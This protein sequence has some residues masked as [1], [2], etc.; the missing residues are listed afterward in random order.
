MKMK[1][2]SNI[3][4]KNNLALKELSKIVGLNREQLRFTIIQSLLNYGYITDEHKYCG[5]PLERILSDNNITIK[6]FAVKCFHCSYP[7]LLRIL[8]GIIIWGTESACPHCGCKTKVRGELLKC[9]NIF[10]DF[11]INLIPKKTDRIILIHL[12]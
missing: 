10:C 7:I 9:T 5:C 8:R 2:I 6:D 11:E 12:N 4:L 3:S 1:Q